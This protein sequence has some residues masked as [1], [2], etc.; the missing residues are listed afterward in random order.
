MGRYQY[1]SIVYDAVMMMA[2]DISG[3][4]GVLLEGILQECV[5][6]A[7]CEDLAD[8][9]SDHLHLFFHVSRLQDQSN[10][11]IFIGVMSSGIRIYR[12]RVLN[13]YFPW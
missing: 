5:N 10:M 13:N 9:C 8:V 3:S 4:R 6:A 11:D 7:Q 12:N 1:C 2:N